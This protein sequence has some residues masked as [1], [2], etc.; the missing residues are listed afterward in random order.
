MDES[1]PCY[2]KPNTKI[3]EDFILPPN[4]DIVCLTSN[5]SKELMDN[6]PFILEIR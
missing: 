3:E 4:L 1:T 5:Q 2:I 6:F